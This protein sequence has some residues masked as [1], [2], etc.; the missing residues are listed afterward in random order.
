MVTVPK[1]Y[2][3]YV[4]QGTGVAMVSI[5]LLAVSTIIA[6]RLIY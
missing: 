3:P 4:L 2:R 5:E 1:P 6:L